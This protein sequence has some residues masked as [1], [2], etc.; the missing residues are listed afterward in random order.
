LHEEMLELFEADEFSRLEAI[1]SLPPRAEPSIE[2]LTPS[3]DVPRRSEARQLTQRFVEAY[4][5]G[6]SIPGGIASNLQGGRGR[7]MTHGLGDIPDPIVVII[8]TNIECL[9]VY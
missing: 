7:R 2:F 1:N 4:S 3:L 6:A 5:I 9:V 8:A